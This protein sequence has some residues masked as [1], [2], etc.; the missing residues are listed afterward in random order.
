M[1]SIIDELSF[2]NNLT[3]IFKLGRNPKYI[4]KNYGGVLIIWDR[5][6]NTFQVEE[7]E[8]AYGL[9]TRPNTLNVFGV[10]VKPWHYLY[11][12]IKKIEGL[13]NKLLLLIMGPSWTPGKPRLGYPSEIPK[14]ST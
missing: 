2:F 7:E 11:Q 14:V 3:C 9:T 4:D 5:M 1:V 8:V 6:F 10:Q 13:K 12:K